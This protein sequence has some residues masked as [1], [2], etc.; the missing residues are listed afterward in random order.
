MF[1]LLLLAQLTGGDMVCWMDMG[2]G[3]VNLEYMCGAVSGVVAPAALSN[4]ALP[5][6][7]TIGNEFVATATYLNLPGVWACAEEQ[8]N[9]QVE[10]LSYESGMFEQF[11]DVCAADIPLADTLTSPVGTLEVVKPRG[12]YGFY[13]RVPNGPKG[14]GPFENRTSARDWAK[15]N[16]SEFF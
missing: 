3:P 5:S 14:Y 2:N 16:F 7:P 13:V 12:N 1:E 11:L 6:D 15:A 9:A 10:N 4:S 8:S